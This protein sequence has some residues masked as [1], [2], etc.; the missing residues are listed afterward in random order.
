MNTFEVNI[1][2]ETSTHGPQKA[3]KAAG[4]WLVEFVTSKGVPVTRSGMI[5][6]E[7]TTENALSLELLRKAFSILTKTCQ[8]RVN[9]SCEHILNTMQN[10]W[11][12]QWRKKDWVNAKGRPVANKE[13]WQQV[14]ERSLI[15]DGN[16]RKSNKRNQI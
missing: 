6:R 10:H 4:E 16:N 2:I 1:Y 14:S 8:I 3:K 9:T 11:L 13:L 7:G 5:Y 12:S 15:N